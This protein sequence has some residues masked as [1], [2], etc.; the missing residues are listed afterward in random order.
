MRV[1]GQSELQ[2]TLSL[3]CSAA[4][5]TASRVIP[6]LVVMYPTY[7][8]LGSVPMGGEHMTMCPQP[9]RSMWGRAFWA[10]TKA[11]RTLTA[12]IRS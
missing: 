5:P 3:W 9:L 2:A 7:P 10:H 4:M 1:T 11:P 6:I 8:G 12:H